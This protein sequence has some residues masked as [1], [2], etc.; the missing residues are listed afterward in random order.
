MNFDPNMVLAGVADQI[1]EMLGRNAITKEEIMG[2][3]RHMLEHIRQ[4][5]NSYKSAIKQRDRYAELLNQ[6]ITATGTPTPNDVGFP[7]AG[8]DLCSISADMIKV[9]RGEWL[10]IDEAPKDGTLVTLLVQYHTNQI[11]D[12]LADEPQVTIGQ[13]SADHTGED[14][15]DI[16]GWCWAHDHFTDATARVIG[17]RPFNRE[18]PTDGA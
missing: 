13:N 1:D 14:R 16:V 15:W 17:W 5:T 4:P 18:V 6:M 7:L 2:N 3:L 8:P 10:D 9:A 11:D 12:Q